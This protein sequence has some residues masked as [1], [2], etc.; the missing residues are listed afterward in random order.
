MNCHSADCSLL[1][2]KTVKS[3]DFIVRLAIQHSQIW[4]AA[5]K[6][7]VTM[8]TASGAFSSSW[9]HILKPGLWLVELSLDVTGATEWWGILP[10]ERKCNGWMWLAVSE[11]LPFRNKWCFQREEAPRWTA[12]TPVWGRGRVTEVF[13]LPRYGSRVGTSWLRSG[14]GSPP[15]SMAD[16][17][18]PESEGDAET[19]QRWWKRKQRV[20]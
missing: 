14:R 5:T 19:Y 11:R 3:S 2:S 13:F 9:I 20:L 8:A 10:H 17:I 4:A 7:S 6:R 15:E 18:A 12:R 1:W 16:G